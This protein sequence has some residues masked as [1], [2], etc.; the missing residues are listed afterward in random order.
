[1]PRSTW[2]GPF[3]HFKI[4]KK[5]ITAKTYVPTTIWSRSSTIIPEF[6]GKQVLIHNGRSFQQIKITNEMTGHKFG[7]FAQTRKKAIHKKLKK[8]K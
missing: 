8:Q 7:E 5:L 4:K 6:I 3:I 2:K 1:M